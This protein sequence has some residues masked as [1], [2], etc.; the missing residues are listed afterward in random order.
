MKAL[1][2]ANV[3]KSRAKFS[4]LS[5]Q[6][7]KNSTFSCHEL[8]KQVKFVKINWPEVGEMSAVLSGKS[9]YVHSGRRPGIS[10]SHF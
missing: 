5:K 7:L 1:D 2:I 6:T 8:S 4:K 10:G 3:A 9:K